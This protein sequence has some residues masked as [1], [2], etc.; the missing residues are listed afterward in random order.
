FVAFDEGRFWIVRYGLPAACWFV[1]S[2]RSC[3]Q[4][5][6]TDTLA[7]GVGEIRGSGYRRRVEDASVGTPEVIQFGPLT[8]STGDATDWPEEVRS[9]VLCRSEDKSGVAVC[10]WNLAGGRARDMSFAHTTETFTA[11]LS[12]SRPEEARNA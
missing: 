10:A 3:G 4:L 2:M 8:W 9:V 6:R 7:G 12:V 5:L 11:T 1:L